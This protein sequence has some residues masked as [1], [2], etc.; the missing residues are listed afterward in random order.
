MYKVLFG[1]IRQ[2]FGSNPN[3]L[4]NKVTERL[5]VGSSPTIERVWY[6]SS[7]GRAPD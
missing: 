1:V 4:Y 2:H 7:V 5:D 6:C 3:A